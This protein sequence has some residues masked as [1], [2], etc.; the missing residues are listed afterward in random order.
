MDKLWLPLKKFEGLYII[1]NYGKV[2]GLPHKMEKGLRGNNQYTEIREKKT[3]INQHGYERICLN[4]NGKQYEKSIHRLVLET[5][6]PIE[7]KMDCNHIDGNKTNNNLQNL[8]WVTEKEN[9]VKAYKLG[10]NP[11]K[12]RHYKCKLSKE[13]LLEISQMDK[14]TNRTH[15]AKQLGV[16]TSYISAIINGKH[17]ISKT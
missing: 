1:S 13:K 10:L 12:E 8:E 17:W 15:L 14:N 9:V 2:F 4:K 7:Q 16:S 5:F 6:K 11:S 3:H